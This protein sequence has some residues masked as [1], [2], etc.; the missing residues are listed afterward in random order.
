MERVIL[1]SDINNCYASIECLYDPALRGKPVAVAGSVEARHGIILAKSEP[2]KRCGV[3]TGEAIWQAQRKCHDLIIVPPHFDRYAKYS[4]LVRNI[5]RRYTDEIEP[6]GLDEAWLDVTGSQGLF[7]DGVKIANEIRSTVSRELGLT[8][9]IGVSFNKIFAKLGS[10][11]KKPDAVTEIT[12]RDFREKIWNLPASDMLGCGRATVQKLQKYGIHTI[13]QLAACDA[14]FLKSVF[15]KGGEELWRYANGLDLSR[16]CPDGFAPVSKSIGHGATC[17]R[18]LKLP[19][20]VWLVMLSLSQEIG[21]RLFSEHLAAISVQ[22]SVKNSALF[23]RQYQCPLPL[24]TQSAFEIAKAAFSLFTSVY[25]WELPV[26]AVTV[27]AISLVDANAPVQTDL[28]SDFARHEQQ[29]RLDAAVRTIRARYGKST[30]FNA[31]LL[32]ETA[33]PH[34]APEHAVLPG[35]MFK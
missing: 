33:I 21:R 27:R 10:D 9:S 20:E 4:E 3:K 17:V 6:F 8:V 5:Y 11:M 1:H 2:A 32:C 19:R 24:P 7:G 15:G 13:G 28:F 22:I 18:D 12:R 26:R 16:V 35:S 29:E 25:R 14:A 34:G 31:C 30:I 23:V